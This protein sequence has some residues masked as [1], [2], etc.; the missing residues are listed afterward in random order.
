[1]C[2][3]LSFLFGDELITSQLCLG[4]DVPHPSQTRPVGPAQVMD[5]KAAL[6]QHTELHA[7]H[8][9]ASHRHPKAEEGNLDAFYAPGL[10]ERPSTE[11]GSL[12]DLGADI[13]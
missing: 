3:T 5:P 10:Q 11:A 9:R 13:C 12:Q 2:Q 4:W 1:M 7:S 8:H 6:L